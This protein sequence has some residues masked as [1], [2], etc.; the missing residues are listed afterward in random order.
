MTTKL[1]NTVHIRTAIEIIFMFCA[2]QV[3]HLQIPLFLYENGSGFSAIALCVEKMLPPNIYPLMILVALAA[4]RL[5][6]PDTAL[7][8]WEVLFCCAFSL[9][10]MIGDSYAAIDSWDLV[11]G[12]PVAFLL[13]AA[14]LMGLTA[15]TTCGLRWLKYLVGKVLEK[16]KNN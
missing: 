11:L 5:N 12:S 10:L 7:K 15:I 3:Q 14:T 1:R 4:F 2:F 8:L 16:E 9:F 13:S 6:V